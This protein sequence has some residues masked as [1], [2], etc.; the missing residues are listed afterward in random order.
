MNRIAE[1]LLEACFLKQIP[2][3]GYQF[4][5]AGGESVAEHVYC[6]AIIA[7]VMS[8]LKPE[9]DGR[10]LLSMCLVHDLAEART[11][12]LNHVQQ[13]YLKRDES[14]ALEDAL[15]GL[16]FG[17]ATVALI[18]EFN[19]AETPEA[20]LA[21]DADQI[22]LIVDLKSL[23]EA[24]YETPQSWLPEIVKRLRTEIG[25]Q[26]AQAV[27]DSQGDSWWRKIFY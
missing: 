19:A 22:A 9:T 1:F 11:G 3:S 6:T 18:D 24:G 4:L 27:L 20:Q 14:R 23:D 21:R 5:R 25:R 15:E 7:F 8:H 10:R 16:S 12:D 2:R 17:D 13:K 26:I